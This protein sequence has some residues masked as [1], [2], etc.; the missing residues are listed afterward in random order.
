MQHAITIAKQLASCPRSS[1]TEVKIIY[2][3]SC[4]VDR[5]QTVSRRFKPSSRTILIGEQPNPWQQMHHQVMMSR[6]RGAKRFLQCGLSENIS[7][8]SLAYLL[9]DNRYV[10]LN[11]IPGQY[12]RL[13]P[14]T[15]LWVCKSN[16]ISNLLNILALA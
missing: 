5:D 15:H 16:L 1:R 12:S 9:F 6:H 8:L 13:S 4:T 2:Y 7:L 11:N 14:F 3:S 10:S